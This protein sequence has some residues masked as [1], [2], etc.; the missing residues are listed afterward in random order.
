[1]LTGKVPLLGVTTDSLL[2]TLQLGRFYELC[3]DL[4]F[5]SFVSLLAKCIAPDPSDRPSS[6]SEVVE[7]LESISAYFPWNEDVAEKWW[8]ANEAD[9]IAFARTKD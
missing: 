2:Q 7:K 4:T 8:R 6:M 3:N 1:M 9:L 5:H